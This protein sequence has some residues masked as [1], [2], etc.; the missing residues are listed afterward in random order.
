MFYFL[1]WTD[2]ILTCSGSSSTISLSRCQLFEAGLDYDALH[3][4]NDSCTGTLQDGRLV[5]HFDNEDHQCGT[6]LKVMVINSNIHSV[7]WIKSLKSTYFVLSF[8]IVQSN[9]THFM[10]QN[11]ILG[12]VETNASLI[13]RARPVNL[14][15]SCVY[16]L[17]EATSMTVKLKPVERWWHCLLFLLL[18]II[19]C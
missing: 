15:Y 11:T 17:N 4:I 8:S 19:Q 14:I 1:R 5:F 13:R 12:G 6:I 9:E 2:S 7:N 18:K 3:L 10:Y 16:P